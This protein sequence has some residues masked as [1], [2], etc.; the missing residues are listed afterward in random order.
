VEIESAEFKIDRFGTP[1]GIP[2]GARFV[3]EEDPSSARRK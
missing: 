2:C 1:S 3:T